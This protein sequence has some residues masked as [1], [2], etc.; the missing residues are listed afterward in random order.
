M[1]AWGPWPWSEVSGPA[2]LA[3]AGA[4]CM[5][6]SLLSTATSLRAALPGRPGGQTAQGQQALWAGPE[7]EQLGLRGPTERGPMWPLVKHGH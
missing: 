4:V 2:L 7:S 5:L 6:S 3:K 1:S